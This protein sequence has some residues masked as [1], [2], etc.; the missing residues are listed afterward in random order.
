MVS[1]RLGREGLQE[2][3]PEYLKPSG[4]GLECCGR[5]G[6]SVVGQQRQCWDESGVLMLRKWFLGVL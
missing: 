2:P 3:D 6:D 1:Y 5:P 4:I